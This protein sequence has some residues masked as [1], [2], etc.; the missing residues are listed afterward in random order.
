MEQNGV[1]MK[2]YE[3]E[4]SLVNLECARDE[5]E[6]NISDLLE[7]EKDLKAES[8]R[9][10]NLEE[11]L[12]SVKKEL[13]LRSP[14]VVIPASVV[15]LGVIALNPLTTL[16]FGLA[17]ASGLAIGKSIQY[18]NTEY[19]K[20]TRDGSNSVKKALKE[21]KR[22]R[23]DVKV[24]YLEVEES[25]SEIQKEI[26]SNYQELEAIDARRRELLDSKT[27]KDLESEPLFCQVVSQYKKDKEKALGLKMQPNKNNG[28][29]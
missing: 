6:D 9:L 13:K 7:K 1:Y 22:S 24:E 17:I 26:E 27:D 16:G 11:T 15:T 5:V 8:E 20:I 21:L 19:P 25:L 29:K 14:L 4:D 12:Y 10:L 28:N 2:K 3:K 18:I 23:R